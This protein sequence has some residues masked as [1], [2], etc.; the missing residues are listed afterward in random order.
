MSKIYLLQNVQTG[1]GAHPASPPTGT[2]GSFRGS[3]GGDVKLTTHH[4][5]VPRLR[6][7]GAISPP[8]DKNSK[9][10]A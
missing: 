6:I 9:C 7:R 5:T 1:T 10:G 8:P 4:Q 3:S 2:D